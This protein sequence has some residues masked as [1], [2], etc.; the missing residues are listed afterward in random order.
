MEDSGTSII[1]SESESDVLGEVLGIV[2][3]VMGTKT[4][5]TTADGFHQMIRGWDVKIDVSNFGQIA[6]INRIFSGI[7]NA[8]VTE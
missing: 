3:F 8:V 4:Q 7:T 6:I 5:S 2:A 1:S